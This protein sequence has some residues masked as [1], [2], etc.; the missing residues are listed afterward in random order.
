MQGAYLTLLW[1][2]LP[3]NGPLRREVYPK[4]L[5]EDKPAQKLVSGLVFRSILQARAGYKDRSSPDYHRQVYK[6]VR[7]SL[8]SLPFEVVQNEVKRAKGGYELL[9]E[10][11]IIGQLRSVFDPVVQKNRSIE[12]RAC[13]S[14]ARHQAD[15]G[16]SCPAQRVAGRGFRF[17]S[18]GQSQR[19]ARYLG[20]ARCAARARQELHP[21]QCRGV[22]QWRGDG[23]LQGSTR[24]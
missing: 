2:I 18:V 12:R 3:L 16:G 13:R 5:V 15:T 4:H 1:G 11:V 23:Y 24:P 19:E 14:V 17:V 7:S 8:D 21:G 9:N 10:G 22:G 6:L 20:G